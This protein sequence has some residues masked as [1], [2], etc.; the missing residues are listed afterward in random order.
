MGGQFNLTDQLD[1]GNTASESAHEYVIATQTWS[2]GRTFQY[3]VNPSGPF[4]EILQKTRL[5]I[6][7]DNQAALAVDAPLALFFGAGIGPARVQA[8]PVHGSPVHEMSA[9]D[10]NLLIGRFP[11][12]DLT[13]RAEDVRTRIERRA[14]EP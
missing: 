10:T 4:R 3:Y 13:G 8:L 5:L 7:R 11:A 9:G 2:G 12:F 1:V 14:Q 6:T